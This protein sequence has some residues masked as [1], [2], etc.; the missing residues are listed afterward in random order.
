MQRKQSP[1][2]PKSWMRWSIPLSC[3]YV[4]CVSVNTSLNIICLEYVSIYKRT[5]SWL[6]YAAVHYT[7]VDKLRCKS[8]SLY[9]C[10]FK[11]II[12]KF[13]FCTVI[14]IHYSNVYYTP[15]QWHSHTENTEFIFHL[16]LFFILIPWFTLVF[17][18]SFWGQ[19]LSKPDSWLL[20]L[21]CCSPLRAPC[22][23]R[24]ALVQQPDCVVLHW[25]EHNSRYREGEIRFQAAFSRQAR[26]ELRAACSLLSVA[27]TASQ[28]VHF[29]QAWWL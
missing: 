10:V 6:V 5:Q 8:L 25:A 20:P 21:S 26:W 1:K 3:L 15:H 29:K 14:E 19:F 7:Q 13:L 11:W 24:T 18:V 17:V 28:P 9:I 4:S 2:A 12:I 22:S 16:F 23:C 27:E